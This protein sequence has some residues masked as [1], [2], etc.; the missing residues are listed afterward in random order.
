M[1]PFGTYQRVWTRLVWMGRIPTEFFQFQ[2]GN[3]CQPVRQRVWDKATLEKA[4]HQCYKATVIQQGREFLHRN[5]HCTMILFQSFWFS[6]FFF[7]FPWA[8][9]A[10]AFRF[11][12]NQS[13][14][15]LAAQWIKNHHHKKQKSACSKNSDQFWKGITPTSSPKE[16]E[17][18]LPAPQ[19]HTRTRRRSRHYF[20]KLSNSSQNHGLVLGLQC[21]ILKSMCA[22]KFSMPDATFGKKKCVCFF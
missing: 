15:P 5:P 2:L 14:G 8:N 17:L 7:L 13:I 16:K 3:T 21:T 22:A 18:L 4:N 10:S 20:K 1:H 11:L 6:F 12:G 9:F 19:T